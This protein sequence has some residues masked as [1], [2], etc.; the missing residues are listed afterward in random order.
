ME[1]LLQLH[2]HDPTKSLVTIAP[3]DGEYILR[4]EDIL[5]T[6]EEHAFSTALIL[7]PGVQYYTGQAFEIGEITKF[8]K[9][10]GIV[11]GWDMAHA[12]GNLDLKLHD[13][14]PD[15]AVWC[16]YKYLNAGPGGML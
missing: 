12:A 14:A 13:W 7:L 16:T 9:K 3:R 8:A 4:T 11:I 6:I 10:L 15:F 5:K 2:G 1:S